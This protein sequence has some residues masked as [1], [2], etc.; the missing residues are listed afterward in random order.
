MDTPCKHPEIKRAFLFSLYTGLRFCDVKRIA[1]T[2]IDRANRLLRFEQSKTRGH[3]SRSRVTIPLNDGIVQ[4]IGTGAA[5]DR[6]FPLKTYSAVIRQLKMWIE[7]AGI[8]KRITWHCARHSFAVNVLSRGADIKTV[9]GLLGHSSVAMTDKYLHV[10]D[11]L[12]KA[13]IDSLPELHIP[14]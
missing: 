5:G 12:K 3:S 8:A 11:E 4:L 7:E 10:V 1:H 13:A 14:K 6:I 9:S 2:D